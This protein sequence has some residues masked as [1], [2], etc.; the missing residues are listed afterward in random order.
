MEAQS[1]E[2]TFAQGY[3]AGK[4]VELC[5]KLKPGRDSLLSEALPYLAP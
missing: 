1:R 4:M 5:L 2:V 3:T